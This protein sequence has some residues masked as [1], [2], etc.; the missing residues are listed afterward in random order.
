MRRIAE[1]EE[2]KVTGAVRELLSEETE[3]FLLIIKY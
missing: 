3:N 1:P 2:E